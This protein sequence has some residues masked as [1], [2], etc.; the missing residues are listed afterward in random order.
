MKHDH[1]SPGGLASLSLIV[2]LLGT[3]A[4]LVSPNRALAQPFTEIF[5]GLP[6]TW[7]IAIQA[8]IGSSNNPWQWLCQR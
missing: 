5:P 4:L 3:I 1:R 6:C 2:P 7:R 8:A